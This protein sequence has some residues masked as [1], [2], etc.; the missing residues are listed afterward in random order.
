MLVGLSVIEG[1]TVFV[2]FTLGGVGEILG[3]ETTPSVKVLVCVIF[4]L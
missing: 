4:T 2:A 1:L 3:S